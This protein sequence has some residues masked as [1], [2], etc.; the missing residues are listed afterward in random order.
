M[1]LRHTNRRL[2]ASVAF[3]ALS[4]L[5]L[6]GRAFYLQVVQAAEL[7]TAAEQ[8]HVREAKL[9]AGRGVIYD[10][11][12]A[13]LAVSKRMASIVANPLLVD[14]PQKTAKSL[15]STL[16]IPKEQLLAGLTKAGGYSILARMVEPSVAARALS[17]GLDGVEVRP[18][19]KRVYPKGALAPQLLG[20]V[21]A[22]GKGLAGLELEYQAVLAGQPGERDYIGDRSGRS[23][24]ILS[25]NEST[26]G[27]SIVLTIDEDIQWQAEQVLSDVLKEFGAKKATAVVLDPRTG[28]ILAM[29]NAP[30]FDTNQFGNTDSL[31]QRNMAVT[32]QYE[33]GSTFK[34]VTVAAALERGLVT[35]ETH[36]TV[37]PSITVSDR[38]VKES[39]WQDLPAV[40]DLSVTEILAQSSNVGTIK[41]GQKVGKLPLVDMIR[42][43]GF[44]QKTGIDFPGEAAGSM[45]PA[46]KWSGSTIANVPIGQ[47]IA[48]TALQMA[49]AYATIAN[50]GVYVQPYLVQNEHIK[51]PTHRVISSVVAAQL[52][53][54]LKDTVSDGTGTAAR[55]QGYV[56]AGKTGTAEK[57]KLKG[58]GYDTDRIVASFVGMVPADSPRLVILVTVDEPATQHFGAVVAAPAF[59]R[60]ADFALKHLEIAPGGAQQ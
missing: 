33:P 2:R 23:L 52:R 57:P 55:V 39:H 15:A 19:D 59:A 60:I 51:T 54:M 1:G 5:M 28:E 38:V 45:P 10:R 35:P 53:E 43:F 44:T 49:A 30:L 37:E 27:H 40:R 58:R 48:A 29:A 36:L 3:V 6:S 14:D 13:E 20:C 26:D 31:L 42:R 9:P 56:V 41:L 24:E 32:D 12:G 34:V 47:G 18:T 17:L 21:G 50:D 4:F 25:D 7:R 11:Q 8:Q 22:N 16:G 46:D